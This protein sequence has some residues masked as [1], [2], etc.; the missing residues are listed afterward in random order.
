MKK[1][2]LLVSFFST[3]Y[4]VLV[5][6]ILFTLY[7]AHESSKSHLKSHSYYKSGA[8]YQALPGENVQTVVTI[9]STDARI[10]ALQ[11]FLTRYDSP[12]AEHAG[13]LIEEADKHKLDYRLLPAI[14]M[15]ES[16]LC[17]K[18]PKNSFNCWGFGIYGKK[19][20]RFDNYDQAIEIVA[21]TLAKNYI[22][23]GLVQPHEIMTKYTP[24]SNGSWA[25]SVSYFMEHIETLL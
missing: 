9:E 12:L 10:V 25:H 6:A 23:E 22:A 8:S 20:T 14:A 11:S 21:K 3:A 17:K 18:I 1:V 4:F 19:V 7:T 13:K 15:Q 5:F 16:N 24:G 2:L